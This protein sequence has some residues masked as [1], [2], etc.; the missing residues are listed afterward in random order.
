MNLF[1][2]VGVSFQP[3][4]PFENLLTSPETQVDDVHHAGLVRE[5]VSTGLEANESRTGEQHDP[6]I[7]LVA[8]HVDPLHTVETK[9][10]PSLIERHR[11]DFH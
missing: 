4:N 9:N 11:E 5:D 8:L 1:V 7:K 10:H 2:E 3:T 6:S